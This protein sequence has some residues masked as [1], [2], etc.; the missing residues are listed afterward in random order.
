MTIFQK[1]RSAFGST[2]LDI[3]A[4]F[5]M[6]RIAISGT[7]SRFYMA[8]DRKTDETIGLKICNSEKVEVFETRFKGL[9]KPSEGEIALSLKHPNIVETLEYGTTTDHS[10]YILMEFLHGPGLH[11]LIR[12][13][14]SIVEGKRVSLI[15]QMAE[16]VEHVHRS[17][18]IHRDICPRN[19]ICD[20][21]A[22]TLKLID[23]GLTLPERRAFRQPG[24]R[25]GTPMYMAPEIVKRRWTDPRVDIF[26]LGV[27]AYHLCTYELPWP[28]AENPAMT[29]M[30][31][32]TVK[33]AD[34]FSL[35][36]DLDP[37]LGATIM[38]C[39]EVDPDKRP[40][41]ATEFLRMIEDVES[42]ART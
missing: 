3:D 26:A 40:A 34:I 6:Q 8:R 42:E 9:K 19:F 1:L 15:K 30:S 36:E 11:V 16:S 35:A 21:S 20:P 7:M 33:P 2:K 39:L 18:Y 5:E 38:Q 29:A 22:K 4:R 25:T 13:R 27:T 31:H 24:N 41:T 32:E 23:F 17:N 12:T 37:T 28:M 14:D 10:Q